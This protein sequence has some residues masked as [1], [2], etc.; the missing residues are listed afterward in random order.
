MTHAPSALVGHAQL[1]LKFFCG[2]AVAGA[3]E[4]VHRVEPFMQRGPRAFHRGADGRMQMVP[5]VLAHIPTFLRHAIKLSVLIAFRTVKLG[6]AV[7]LD[8][9]APQ[10]CFVVRELALELVETD[11]RDLLCSEYREAI[12]LCQGDNCVPQWHTTW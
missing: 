10:A 12:P 9:D 4:Q 8:H 6:A 11:H 1:A 7:A 2:H 5:T 3:R